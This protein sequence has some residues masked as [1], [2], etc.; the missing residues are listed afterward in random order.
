MD[1]DIKEKV[2]DW[3]MD[4]IM[5]GETSFDIK[6]CAKDIGLDPDNKNDVETINKVFQRNNKKTE[7]FVT[8]SIM[9][10]NDALKY[11]YFD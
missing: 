2:N 10:K 7:E 1:L 3:I 8:F 6:V 9:F 4:K 11:N 5:Q